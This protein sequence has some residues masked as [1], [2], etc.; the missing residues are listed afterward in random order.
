MFTNAQEKNEP[1]DHRTIT[2]TCDERFSLHYDRKVI[3]ETAAI[4]DLDYGDYSEGKDIT[5]L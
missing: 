1:C 4:D 3:D 5:P 2:A